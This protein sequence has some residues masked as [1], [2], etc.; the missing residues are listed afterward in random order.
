MLAVVPSTSARSKKHSPNQVASFG[1]SIESSHRISN[2]S[3]FQ[4]VVESQG[5]RWEGS[6]ESI[7]LLGA[8]LRVQGYPVLIPSQ[9]LILEIATKGC[10]VELMGKV[11]GVRHTK[12]FNLT[13][14]SGVHIDIEFTNLNDLTGHRLKLILRQVK[15][16]GQSAFL[17]A[18]SIPPDKGNFL[19]RM[20]NTADTSEF[21]ADL[22]STDQ[23]ETLPFRRDHLQA[24]R[25]V[26]EKDYT[27]LPYPDQGTGSLLHINSTL[28]ESFN[29][30]GQRILGYYDHLQGSRPSNSP[31][32][33]ITPGY[34]ET[35][36]EYIA[37]A[38]YL[39]ANG[40]HVVRY[41]HTNH[42]GE[43]EGHHVNTSLSS[44]K[45]DLQAMIGLC[46]TTLA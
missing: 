5:G 7:S 18:K 14:G 21:L 13:I 29:S 24:N 1:T 43:S 22:V 27:Q 15:E 25:I 3:Q 19:W 2:A 44:M 41:D 45:D 32:V 30:K 8:T 46:I 39:A 40:F 17:H 26:N 4:A 34:G 10:S 31:V 6:V 11:G 23:A 38:Y 36:R 28:I 33:L 37:L 16:A 12:D 20:R 42:V 35:K 9:G